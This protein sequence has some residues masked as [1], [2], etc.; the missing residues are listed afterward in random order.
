MCIYVSHACDTHL[1]CR[2]EVVHRGTVTASS[3]RKG[4][5]RRHTLLKQLVENTKIGLEKNQKNQNFAKRV[6]LSDGSC[7]PSTSKRTRHKASTPPSQQCLQRAHT[8]GTS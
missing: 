6:N 4:T 7:S 5:M 3:R 2:Q 8:L 1:D